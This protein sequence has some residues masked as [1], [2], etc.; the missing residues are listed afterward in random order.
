[1]EQ[2]SRVPSAF[3]VRRA[4]PPASRAWFPKLEIHNPR[5]E[6]KDAL[7]NL[8]VLPLAGRARLAGAGNVPGTHTLG[9]LALMTMSCFWT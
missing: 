9:V 2:G 8:T 1:M 7:V 4:V 5:S 6:F 3:R